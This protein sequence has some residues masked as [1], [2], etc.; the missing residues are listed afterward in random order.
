[1]LD[2]PYFVDVRGDGK[3]A[4]SP[5]TA[6]VPQVTLPWVSPIDVDTT[7]NASRTVV[8]LLKSSPDSWRSTSMDVMPKIDSSGRSAFTPEGDRAAAVLGVSIEGQFNSYFADKDNPLLAESKDAKA[9]E[10]EDPDAATPNE[11]KKGDAGI[12][13]GIIDKSPESAR[14]FVFGSNTFLSDQTLAMIG[15]AEGT[16]YGNS[17]QLIANAVDWSLE[18]RGLLA[19]RSRGHFN[20]TLPPV[21][22]AQRMTLEYSNYGIALVLL[23]LIFALHTSRAKT[24][25]A[26]YR[27]WLGAPAGDSPAFDSTG[28]RA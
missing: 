7:K 25:V 1:M 21:P 26:K 13:T 4:N 16:V 27:R 17:M 22:E 18:D 20:R 15:S 10:S 2:Y 23:G 8:E 11:P 19:I 3:N 9:A 28:A 6:D 14:L 5:I 24:R 12:I